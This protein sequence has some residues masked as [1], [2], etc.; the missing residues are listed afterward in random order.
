LGLL[1]A[2]AH[3]TDRTDEDARRIRDPSYVKWSLLAAVWM[4]LFFL[5]AS[6]VAA[7]GWRLAITAPYAIAGLMCFVGLAWSSPTIVSWSAIPVFIA[8][9]VQLV[10]FRPRSNDGA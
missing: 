6:V 7:S 8:L 2:M 5:P 1:S 3:G 9:R 10:V 4:A